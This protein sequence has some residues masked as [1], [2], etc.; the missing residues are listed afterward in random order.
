MAKEGLKMADDSATMAQHG[1]QMAQDVFFN[2]AE[3]DFA[4]LM[5]A[6]EVD[7]AGQ[8]GC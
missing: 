1:R 5:P 8:R 7:F 4:G 6:V 3:V 2:A